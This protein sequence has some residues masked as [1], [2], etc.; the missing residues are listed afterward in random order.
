MTCGKSAGL[1]QKVPAGVGVGGVSYPHVS[2]HQ[3]AVLCVSL[4]LPADEKHI[5]KCKNSCSPHVGPEHPSPM[6]TNLPSNPGELT[7][8]TYQPGATRLACLDAGWLMG[9]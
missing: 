1:K 4:V 9:M 2:L 3:S 5:S 7:V 8:P 6:G